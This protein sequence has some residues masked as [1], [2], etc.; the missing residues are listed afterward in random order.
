MAHK[1]ALKD[2]SIPPTKNPEWGF[3]REMAERA[4][5][6][7][8]LADSAIAE[9]TKELKETAALFLDSRSLGIPVGLPYL[10]GFVIHSGILNE[11][12]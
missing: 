12:S 3:W 2:H 7:W 11:P 8:P 9:E 10:L 6:A 1:D 5:E 4:K